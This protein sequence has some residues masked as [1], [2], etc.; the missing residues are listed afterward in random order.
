MRVEQLVYF[1]EVA[2]THSIN[3]A[4]ENLFVTQPGLSDSIKKMES[5]LGLKLLNRSK[6]GVSL[7][8]NGKI[9][10][11]HAITILDAYQD[12]LN[13]L[14][15]INAPENAELKGT[16]TIA[17]PP[18]FAASVLTDVNAIFRNTYPQANVRYVELPEKEIIQMVKNDQADLGFYATPHFPNAHLEALAND[19]DLVRIELFQ[20]EL[21]VCM[22]QL[23]PLAK[24]KALPA[25][26]IQTEKT[27]TFFNYDL[28][29]RSN[30]IAVSNNIIA[31]INIIQDQNAIMFLTR[32]AYDRCFA[33]NKGL[34]CLPLDSPEN[35]TFSMLFAKKDT[36]PAPVVTAYIQLMRE[37]IRQVFTQVSF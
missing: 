14:S 23:S 36:D 17:V 21:I 8:E 29:A 37:H 31:L 24:Q 19:P 3:K 33:E 34:T 20:D 6:T 32:H 18:L 15:V 22:S 27:V 9:V 26:I 12:M 5:E 4:A 2:K 35:V 1:L 7:T 28:S 16:L 25:H 30:V 11:Q 10:A 13:D